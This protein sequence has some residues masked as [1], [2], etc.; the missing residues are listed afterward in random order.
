MLL[1][2][3]AAAIAWTAVVAVVL[4][5]CMSA[6]HGDRAGGLGQRSARPA[7]GARGAVLSLPR[8]VTN[9]GSSASVMTRPAAPASR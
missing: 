9:G 4:G 3:L 6:A 7:T 2:A 8:K 5:V 1:I